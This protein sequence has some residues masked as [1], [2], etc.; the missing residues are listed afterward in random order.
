MGLLDKANEYLDY[1]ERKAVAAAISDA[2]QTKNTEP[3]TKNNTQKRGPRKL[4]HLAA[5]FTVGLLMQFT[6]PTCVGRVDTINKNF[7]K[8]FIPSQAEQIELN[9]NFKD[10]TIEKIQPTETAKQLA[11]HLLSPY[12]K[13][14]IEAFARLIYGEAGRGA[15]AFEVAHTVGNRY[16]SGR[17]GKTLM[18]VITAENQYVGYRASNKLTKK[19]YSTA[20]IMLA[21]QV[22]LLNYG[23]TLKELL[24]QIQNENNPEIVNSILNKELNKRMIKVKECPHYYFHLGKQG[25]YNLFEESPKVQV[26][27]SK[28]KENNYDYN[29]DWVDYKDKVYAEKETYCDEANRQYAEYMENSKVYH[30]IFDCEKLQ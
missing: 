10:A 5:V 28:Q 14:E 3:E 27:N 2:V 18:D 7:K 16:A 23:K 15:D 20:C 1:A 4:R 9:N 19:H 30:A 22:A 12:S 26:K 11:R 21:D 25:Y 13:T 6:T 29:C 8:T 17:F 24:I